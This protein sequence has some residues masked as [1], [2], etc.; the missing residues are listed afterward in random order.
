VAAAGRRRWVP[1]GFM[2]V[3]L[4]FWTS[5]ILVALWSLGAAA[6]AGE[7]G[8]VLVLAI[9][10]VAAGF[11]LRSGALRLKAL[12]MNEKPPPSPRRNRAWRDGIDSRGP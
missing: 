7:P 12:L 11:A 10:L 6:L 4:T 1:I 2:V 3:W 8:A 5:A 9:W